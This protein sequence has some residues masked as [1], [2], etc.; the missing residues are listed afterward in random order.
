MKL[1]KGDKVLIIV[2]IIFSLLFAYYM[3]TVNKNLE[4]KYVSIQI[5]GEE[6]NTIE[7]SKDIIGET[8]VLET[9]F[10]RNVLKFGDGEV[11]IIEASCPDQ[12]CVK[13]GKIGQVGQ[14]IVCLPNRLVVEIKAN[15]AGNDDIDNIVF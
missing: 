7:F 15:N 2:L 8:Y 6:I 11:K 10:G 3:A 14:L 12:L 4:K 13:Q 5:N 9:E 1:T